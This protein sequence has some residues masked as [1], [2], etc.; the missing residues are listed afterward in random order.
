[1]LEKPLN[2]NQVR[3]IPYLCG[4]QK[5][6]SG[7]LCRQNEEAC[8]GF[9]FG[10]LFVCFYCVHVTKQKKNVFRV[11]S[12]S[13]SKIRHNGPSPQSNCFE[14]WRLDLYPDFTLY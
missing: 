12:E 1:M 6:G 10:V 8:T 7:H 14:S 3:V 4:P 11:F 9:W 13:L 2:L 5:C